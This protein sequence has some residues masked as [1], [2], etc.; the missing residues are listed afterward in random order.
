MASFVRRSSPLF[1]ITTPASRYIPQTS[2]HSHR[3][4]TTRLY[5][6]PSATAHAEP[7]LPKEKLKSRWRSLKTTLTVSGA[8]TVGYVAYAIYEHRHPAEQLPQ[9]SSKKRLVILGSGWAA[10]SMLK[11]LDT[12]NYQVTVVSPRNYFL[13]TPL[14]PSCTVGTIEHRS[15]MEPIRYI[16]R[17]KKTAVKFLEAE[18]QNID[19]KEKTIRISDNSEITGSASDATIP[20]DYLVVACGATNQ[21]FG[22]PGVHEHACFLKEIWDAHKI[23]TRLMDCIETAAFEGQPADEVE[24]LLHMVVVGGGPSGV[25]F[26]AELHDFLVGDLITWYPELAGKL[27]ITLVEALPNVLPMFSKKLI[28]YTEKTFAENKINIMTK[29]AVKEVKQKEI[30]VQNPDKSLTT[31]PYGLLV[32]ATGNT[33]RPVVRDLMAKL[34]EAQTQRRGLVVD[35]FMNVAGADGVYAVGDVTATKYA[36]TAQVA[37]Q[38]GSYLAQQFNKMAR[39]DGDAKNTPFKYSHQGSLAYIGSDKAIFDLPFGER[40]FSS[41][42]LATYVFWRSA[43]LSNLFSVRNKMLVLGDWVK[44]TLFGRDIGRE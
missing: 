19:P 7:P 11:S 37:S 42:G 33:S 6:T 22:I 21:T 4:P 20:Y 32:W 38:Q 8:L 30:V 34:P 15:I 12:S 23:R 13:F 17:Q 41:G 2:T 36:P 27:K 43:Y 39:G 35:D 44:T 14:L 28:E 9:D 24:R 5:S 29:T 18:V 40:N 16:T 3:L 25:E 31:V 1:R 26:G 10:T